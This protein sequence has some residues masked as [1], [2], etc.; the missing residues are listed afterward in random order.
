M[1]EIK[2]TDRR[3]LL[4]YLADQTPDAGWVDDVLS[5][6]KKITF[7]SGVFTFEPQD[8]VVD[9]DP[10]HEIYIDNQERYFTF[11]TVSGDYYEIDRRILRTKYNVLFYKNAKIAKNTFVAYQNIS[12]FKKIDSLTNEQIIIG[13]NHKNAITIEDFYTLLKTFPNSTEL[14][15]YSN[16]RISGQLQNYFATMDDAQK[17]LQKYLN[18]KIKIEPVSSAFPVL[19]YELGK[20]L[21]IRNTFTDMLKVHDQYTEK[22]WQNLIADFLPLIFPKYISVLKEVRIKDYISKESNPVSRYIDFMLVDSSGAI[23]IVEIKKPYT[24]CILSA[25]VYRDNY[26]PH[27]ELSGSIMQIEKYLFHLSKSGNAGELDIV[28]KNQNKIPQNLKLKIINPKGMVIL[29]RDKDFTPKQQFDFEII[30]R[31]YS[32]IIDILTYD[33]ILSRLNNTIEMVTKTLDEAKSEQTA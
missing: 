15:H 8:I 25:G 22:N 1:I 24:S 28:S 13:G 23:D 10:D 5:R 2:K 12:I 6:E 16:S 30:R 17:K 9:H 3:L 20:F 33:D 32:N 7:S 18:K 19:E 14:K 31:K 29:G 27:R 11:G 21:Y 26:I 4:R